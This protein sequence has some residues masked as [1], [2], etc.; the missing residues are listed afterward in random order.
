MFSN[1]TSLRQWFTFSILSF[2]VKSLKI[3]N[4]NFIF[5]ST[6]FESKSAPA[7]NSIPIS[8]LISVSNCLFPLVKFLPSNKTFPISGS[9]RPTIHFNNTLFPVPLA[10]IIKFVLPFMNFPEILKI[11]CLSLKDFEMFFISIIY[12]RIWASI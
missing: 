8:L 7:W 1:P 11:T 3:S 10:P 12:K 9:R 4:G 5:S 2:S 6:F